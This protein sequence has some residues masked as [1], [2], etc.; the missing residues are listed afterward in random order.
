ML[1]EQRPETKVNSWGLR[2]KFYGIASGS[3]CLKIGPSE[4]TDTYNTFKFLAFIGKTL[5]KNSF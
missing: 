2:E 1:F 4:F 5:Y 3:T